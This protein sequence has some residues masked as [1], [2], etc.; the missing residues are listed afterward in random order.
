VNAIIFA[1]RYRG[2]ANDIVEAFKCEVTHPFNLVRKIVDTYGSASLK[3]IMFF[4]S[5]AAR[6]ILGD[7]SLGYHLSK[8]SVSHLVRF[9]AVEF[10]RKDI[11][12][13]GISPSSFV[14]KARSEEYY[15]R[16]KTLKDRFES[17]I[18]SGKFVSCEEI[19]ELVYHISIS[20]NLS[21]S[22]N[23]LELDHGLGLVEASTLIRDTN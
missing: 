7:Q 5:P 17:K 22:G 21:L 4:T 9:L 6:K 13:V 16:N 1:H 19:A 18:P 15:S 14:A 12:V 20:N 3:N 23:I 11:S 2:D 10:A 8:T